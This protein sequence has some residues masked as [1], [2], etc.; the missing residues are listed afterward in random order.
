LVAAKERL[1]HDDG[2]PLIWNPPPGWPPFPEGWAPEPGWVPPR[3][4]PKPPAGWEFW[5]PEEE[6]VQ[7]EAPS[8]PV[9]ARGRDGAVTLEDEWVTI[10][11]AAGA[12]SRLG[13]S[14]RRYHV[15]RIAGVDVGE[16]YI[17]LVTPTGMRSGM[18]DTVHFAPG[19][20][21]TFRA[22][23]NRILAV[24]TSYRSRQGK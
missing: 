4:W 23:R 16:S 9:T 12:S 1:G 7:E 14:R 6:E 18:D 21:A 19:Q 17:T 22:L 24:R 11:R 20:A 13:E 2:V 3:H 15:S 5:I 8:G 10:S